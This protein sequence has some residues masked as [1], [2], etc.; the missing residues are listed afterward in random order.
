LLHDFFNGKRLS[1]RVQPDEAVAYGAAVEVGILKGV[2]WEI[3]KDLCLVDVTPLPLGVATRGEIM[4]VLINRKSAIPAMRSQMF[5]MYTDSQTTV[6][7]KVYEGDR[8]LR[9]ENFLLE[10]FDLMG[11]RP[12]PRGVPGIEVV[13]DVQMDGI[14]TISAQDKATVQGRRITVQRRKSGVDSGANLGNIAAIPRR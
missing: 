14:M 11:I 9:R 10:S 4:S 1:H 5:A 2:E 6:T 12:A 8:S 7:I 3:S 13:F